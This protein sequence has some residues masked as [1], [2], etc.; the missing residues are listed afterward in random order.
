MLRTQSASSATDRNPRDGS[1]PKLVYVSHDT[2]SVKTIERAKYDTLFKSQIL[3][4]LRQ[5]FFSIS[6]NTILIFDFIAEP[7]IRFHNTAIIAI[8]GKWQKV[9]I[10]SNNIDSQVFK[11][12]PK[13]LKTG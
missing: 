7:P 12:N 10:I 5:R 13:V 4:R 2:L 9:T 8:L 1:G 11:I 3:Y 6:G